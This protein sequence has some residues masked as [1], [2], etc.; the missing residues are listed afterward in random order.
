VPTALKAS[1]LPPE[2]LNEVYPY[3]PAC[4]MAGRMLVEL[5]GGTPKKLDVTL[6]GK[7]SDS[8]P[9]VLINGIV[10]GI[11]TYKNVGDANLEDAEDMAKRHGMEITSYVKEFAEEYSSA[12]YIKG[13]SV[14]LAT[15]LYG[16]ERLPRIISILGY[17]IDIAPAK[18]SLVIEYADGPGRIGV[19][20]TVLGNA[21]INITT[22][23]IATRTD[24][25]SA[26][27]YVNL[28][29]NV[30]DSVIEEIREAIDLKNIWRISL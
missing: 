7:L 10:E 28:E 16:K 15:T 9:S 5:N 17:K 24:D 21:G 1:S 8:D 6:E 20:G 29:G 19:I 2:L 14:E 25:N 26:L 3:V 27:V 13:D 4:K 23:Q 11:I 12:L 18:H 22:M 30:D